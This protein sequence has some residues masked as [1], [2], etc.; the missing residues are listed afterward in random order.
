[1]DS[2]AAMAVTRTLQSWAQETGNRDIQVCTTQATQGAAIAAFTTLVGGLAF[3]PPGLA[4]GG[5]LGGLLAMAT[6]EEFDSLPHILSGMAD[7]QKLV[8]AAAARGVAVRLGIDMLAQE[9]STELKR[10]LL[11]EVF[12]ALQYHVKTV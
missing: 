7:E 5:A 10:A 6:S 4:L 9:V 2:L 3:G 12:Q 8:V 11:I 1:M